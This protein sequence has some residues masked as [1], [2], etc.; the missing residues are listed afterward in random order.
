MQQEQLLKMP[1]PSLLLIGFGQI[2]R[3]VANLVKDKYR[4]TAVSKSPKQQ[5]GIEH[6][7]A[8]LSAAFPQNWTS[9]Y[10]FLV[11]CLSPAEFTE[12]AYRQVFQDALLNTLTA[13]QKDP[14]KR[15]FFVSSTSVY[16][17]NQGEWVTEASPTN[18][19]SFSGKALVEAEQILRNQPFPTTSVRFSGIYG[20][21]R[22]RFL[23][24]V[25]QGRQFNP[26]SGFT[27]RIFEDDAVGC[28]VHLL[29][30]ANQDDLLA[31]CYLA[32]DDEPARLD[33]IAAWIRD[34]TACRAAQNHDRGKVRRAGSKRC[35]NRLLKS[36]GFQF[37]YP[38]FRVGYSAIL[39]S[40]E[41][42]KRQP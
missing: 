30:R 7:Q 16:G 5:E 35:S 14:P 17:Q 21:H 33:E 19:S 36:S 6:I 12:R 3:R 32:S 15:L 25:I 22:T 23:E 39:A 34:Q 27:N 31:D 20:F 40:Q 2:N 11:F 26:Q 18:P 41:W 8:D 10:D 24:S 1:K 13:L 29:E 37:Q 9:G 28:L 38:N 42:L 4:I